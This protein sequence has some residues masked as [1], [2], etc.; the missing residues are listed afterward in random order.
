[1]ETTPLLL[2]QQVRHAQMT[3]PPGA[4]SLRKARDLCDLCNSGSAFDDPK[5]SRMRM[6]LRLHSRMGAGDWW[7]LLGYA[8]SMCD[9]VATHRAKLTRIWSASSPEVRHRAMTTRNRRALDRLP[10]VLTV[11]RGCYGYLNEKGFSWSLSDD[12]ARTFP[13]LIRY[14]IDDAV[15][16]LLTGTVRKSD[17]LLHLDR[18]ERE[19]IA[20]SSRV[21]IAGREVLPNRPQS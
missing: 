19:V 3:I 18:S 2:R 9:D 16:L 10:D 8:W 4:V 1:M 21:K 15:P 14:R 13:F 7:A 6:V 17:V 11:Y 5:F 20:P 12:I